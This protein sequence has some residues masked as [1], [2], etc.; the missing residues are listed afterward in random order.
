[1]TQ[2]ALPMLSDQDDVSDWRWQLQ[3][4]ITTAAELR[5]SLDL[6]AE[7]IQGAE[8]AEQAGFPIS[9]SPYYLG[10]IDP[11]DPSCPIRRQV[12][13]QLAES[14]TATTDMRDPLGEELHQV[15]PDLIQRYPDRALLLATDRCSVYCRFCTRSRMVGQGGGMRSL[16][17]PPYTTSST[18]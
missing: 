17:R 6:S 15:A 5:A 12:V 10:L 18:R 14:F 7:E 3:N 9:I 1:M 11:A 13:P 16:K 4:A 8:H 2:R